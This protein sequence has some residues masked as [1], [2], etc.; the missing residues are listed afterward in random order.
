MAGILF[1][2]I[3]LIA[4]GELVGGIGLFAPPGSTALPIGIGFLAV[5]AV[6]TVW[7]YIARRRKALRIAAE[8]GRAC[9]NGRGVSFPGLF[10]IIAAS[11]AVMAA[12]EGIVVYALAGYKNPDGSWLSAG[13]QFIMIVQQGVSYPGTTTLISGVIVIIL[14]AAA[15]IISYQKRA[16]L[17]FKIVN[18]G[19]N[20]KRLSFFRQVIINRQFLLLMVPGILFTLVFC[21]LPMPGVIIAFK[22]LNLTMSNFIFNLLSSKWYG[23]HNLTTFF[24]TPMFWI[25]TR[26]TIGYNF[27]FITFGLIGNVALALALTELRQR[28]P[29]LVFQTVF[30]FPSFISWVIVSFLIYAFLN[31]DIGIVNTILKS[32]GAAP[33]SWYTQLKYWPYLLFF[34]Q[35][36]KGLGMGCIIYIS[37]L[38]GIDQ[39][40]FQAAQIDGASKRQQIFH[41]SLPGLRR[42][43]ILLTI[44]AIGGIMNTDFGLF[45][46]STLQM[47]NGMLTNVAN[48]INV[49]VYQMLLVK[50]NYSIGGAV[51]LYQSVIGFI[52]VMVTNWIV[53][54]IDPDSA[55]I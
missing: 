16:N 41:I 45:Y 46:V 30:I 54:R 1:T 29:A 14:G 2:G 52:L 47:G 40:L 53:R 18:H 10:A 26:N 13:K 7:A 15:L 12:G 3:F 36:W 44:M 38:S 43:M 21:Y 31:P 19:T 28:K 22:R 34:F 39:E 24:K 4:A 37:T 17:I 55:L 27:V 32:A 20:K 9:V 8:D 5:G 33:I 49:Y 25:I 11:I 42:V 35:M 51:S 48:T 50:P 6:L 23:L